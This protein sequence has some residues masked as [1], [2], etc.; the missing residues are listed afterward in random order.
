[1][2]RVYDNGTNAAA[3]DLSAKQYTFVKVT[4]ARAVNSATALGE[5][6]YGVLQNKPLAGDP[7]VVR[8]VGVSLV[9]ASA[10]IAA[11]A[12]VTTTA[13]GLAVTAAATQHIVGTALEAATAANDLIEVDILPE[14]VQA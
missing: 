1:M 2:Q 5:R 12:K 14:G 9:K 10:A 4:G 3:A 13:T 6:T 7:A 8:R 11:G